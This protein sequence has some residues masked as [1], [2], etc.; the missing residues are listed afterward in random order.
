MGMTTA[1]NNGLDF[2]I[3]CKWLLQTYKANPGK[4]WTN[5]AFDLEKLARLLPTHFFGDI[6]LATQLVK[7]DVYLWQCKQAETMSVN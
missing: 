1:N 7:H 4:I 3:L 2:Q 6:I 5:D